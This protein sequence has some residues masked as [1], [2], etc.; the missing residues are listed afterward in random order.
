MCDK[1]FLSSPPP[2]WGTPAPDC[3]TGDTLL[4]LLNA[5]RACAEGRKLQ[6]F[7]LHFSGLG[8]YRPGGSQGG[9]HP[10]PPPIPPQFFYENLTLLN[11]K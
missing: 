10:A 11:F 3:A 9:R 5:V 1:A 2:Q 4:H 6:A 8:A 7:A